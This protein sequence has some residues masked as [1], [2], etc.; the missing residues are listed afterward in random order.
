MLFVALLRRGE[1]I[2]KMEAIMRRRDVG[3]N[4]DEVEVVWAQHFGLVCTHSS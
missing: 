1:E 4:L 3:D 2:L